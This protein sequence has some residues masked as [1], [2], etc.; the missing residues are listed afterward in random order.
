VSTTDPELKRPRLAALDGLRLVG[1]LAVMGFHYVGVRIPHWGVPSSTKFPTLHEIG[2]YGYLGVNL[3]FVISGYVILMTAY[4]RP[5]ES[6]TASRV[7]RLFPAYWVAVAL[8]FTLQQF[9]HH[10]RQPSPM[11][12]LVNLTMT[13][14][15]FDVINVQ[16]AFWTLWI[17]LKFYLLVAVFIVVGITRRRLL[18]FAV[19]WPLIGQIAL[20][21]K[22]QFLASLLIPTY[23]PYFAAGILLFLMFHERREVVTWLALGF[24]WVLCVRQAVHHAPRASQ[25]AGAPVSPSVAAIVVT[26]AIAAVY[27]CSVGPLSRLSWRWMTLAGAL[28]YPLYL[29]HGQLGFFLIDTLHERLSPYLVLAVAAVTSLVVAW[30]IHRLVEI[31]FGPRLRQAIENSLRSAFATPRQ[32][33]SPP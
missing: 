7:A 3:F 24:N 19:L 18:A 32:A 26:L 2:R 5:I 16:G 10:G 15:A 31:P 25:Y 14:E 23:A 6:F 22:S 27:L 1:A 30:L 28:T 8:T 29:V 12:A 13:Q 20:A 9:W 11:A 17:E 33:V 4:N 21:T